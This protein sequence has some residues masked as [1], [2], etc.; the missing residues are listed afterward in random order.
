MSS[1]PNGEKA[2][3]GKTISTDLKLSPKLQEFLE[4][5][6]PWEI[7]KY[8]GKQLT[9]G[10]WTIDMYNKVLEYS[11]KRNTTITNLRTEDFDLIEDE[12]FKANKLTAELGMTFNTTKI[13]DNSSNT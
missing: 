4:Q 8:A 9:T 3:T 12:D 1:Q 13:D 6:T 7:I 10:K 2:D 11:R 5:S